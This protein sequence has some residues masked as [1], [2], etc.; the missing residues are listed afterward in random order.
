MHLPVQ[1]K[2]RRYSRRLWPFLLLS[3]G[4]AS[5]VITHSDVCHAQSDVETEEARRRFQEGVR[6][7]DQRQYD[8][9]RLSFLQAYA[10]KPHPAVLLNLA[11]SE[12]RAGHYAEAATNFAKYIRENPNADAM[13]HARGAFEEAR[14][15]VVEVNVAVNQPDAVVTV[16]GI[17]A[18]KS[19]LP[20]VLYVEPGSRTIGAEKDG[21]RASHLLRA[22]AGQ[23]LYVTLELQ[24]P[25]ANA[26]AA[27]AGTPSTVIP[28]TEGA[29]PTGSDTGNQPGLGFFE[30]LGET[31]EAIATVTVGGLALGTS[32]ILA[33]FAS[34]RYD[35][36]NEV[37]DAI[38]VQLR[39]DIDK[40]LILEPATPCGPGGI[41]NGVVTYNENIDTVN[42][43]FRDR[44]PAEY[45]RACDSFTQRADSGDRLKTFAFVALGVGAAAT[46]ATIVWYFT[47]TSTGSS[48]GNA[49]RPAG[50]R[51]T[52]STETLLVPVVSRE[53]QG[54]WLQ[55]S[56]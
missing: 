33:A 25:W 29:P 24:A 31:P 49:R 17:E 28:S 16:D 14:K 9:A 2:V 23:R 3:Y 41:A 10:L 21:A 11:Q 52:S 1:T 46:V 18:G 45:A 4:G 54:L 53:T 26:P 39:D 56:F 42:P 12:L 37:K 38:M 15:R 50:K 51:K 8:K 35:D 20:D 5:A 7:Y 27:V 55:F 36:A 44:R 47:D 40:N 30:W 6:Y 43:G 22:E 48:S 32:A 34:K 19:P 13:D